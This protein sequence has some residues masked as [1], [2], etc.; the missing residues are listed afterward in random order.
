MHR[1]PS[2]R[3][4]TT[5]PS[6]ALGSARGPTQPPH[7]L[8]SAEQYAY[9]QAKQRA[10]IKWLLS[11]AYSHK[12]P[13]ELSEP[14]Y[15]DHD[16]KSHEDVDHLKPHI[17]HALANAELYCMALSILYSDPNYH[18]LNHW[19]IIQALARKGIYVA[20]PADCALT[21]TVLIQT[22]PL[23]MS[24]HM[25]VTEAVMG[26]VLKET[27]NVDKVKGVIQRL[28]K[29]FGLEEQELTSERA[30]PTDQE[31]AL[32][33]WVNACC[34]VAR[35]QSEEQLGGEDHSTPPK[36]PKVQD[37]SDLSDGVGLAVV[38]SLYCPDE[39]A[40]TE[41]AL[42]DPPSM[43]DSLYNIQLVQ[44][45]CQSTPSFNHCHLSIEDFVYLHASIK[46]NV[47]CFMAD[48]FN[49]L[50]VKPIRPA[51]VPGVPKNQVI[52][53]PDPDI[54][55]AKSPHVIRRQASSQPEKNEPSSDSTFVVQRGRTVPTLSSVA[56]SGSP[57]LEKEHLNTDTKSEERGEAEASGE[58][59]PRGGHRNGSVF[60][61]MRSIPVAGRP[62]TQESPTRGYKGIAGRRSRRNS[63]D[64]NTSQLSLE[65]LGGSQDN[66]HLLSRNPDKEMKTHSGRIGP[67]NNRYV[68][69]REV[70]E[71]EKHARE[72]VGEK[73][74]ALLESKVSFA[75]LRKQKARDQFH[76]SGINI[77]YMHDEKE[78]LPKQRRP[79]SSSTPLQR[80][81]SQKENPNPGMTSWSNPGANQMGQIG[82]QS[83]HDDSSSSPDAMASQLN[84]V[85]M[86]LEQ[87]RKKIEEEKKKMESIM[88]KQREKVGQEAFL[89]AV[90]VKTSS[91]TSK[92]DKSQSS[93][94]APPS[95]GGATNKKA[96]PKSTP[97]RPVTFKDL[98]DDISAVQSRWLSNRGNKFGDPASSVRTP[99]I[100][101]MD[102]DTYTKSLHAMNDSL[103]ELQTDIHRLA[104]QQTQIQH[105]MHQPGGRQ[106]SS[107]SR[108]PMDPQPFYI[109]HE[110]QQ[111]P[112][113]RTWGQPQPI[114]FAHQ[115]SGMGDQ[116]HGGW[117]SPQRQQWGQ[118]PMGN[119]GGF[120]YGP[121]SSQYNDPYGQPYQMQNPMYNGNPPYDQPYGGYGGMPPPTQSFTP[122][123]N[124][125][126]PGP[127]G[128]TSF[129]SPPQSNMV[130]PMGV[131]ASP[132]RVTPFRL[133]DKV[134]SSGAGNPHGS[135]M[136]VNNSAL[137]RNPP[138]G[139]NAA[140]LGSP[141][142]GADPAVALA[143]G[144]GSSQSLSRQTSR[145]SVNGMPG[146]GHHQPMSPPL[147]ESARRL[148]TSVPAPEE[149]DMAPQNISFI[150]DTSHDEGDRRSS[151]PVDA[152]KRLPER[153]SQL[154][155]SSGSKTYRV[156]SSPDKDPSP[157]PTRNRPTISS[158]FKQARRSSGGEN[159]LTS[160]GPSSIRSNTGQSG[161]TE[162]EAETLSQM[163]TERLKDG[164]EAAK[165]F[166]ITFEDDTPKKPKPQLK[167]RRPSSK[168]NSMVFMGNELN[169][170][171]SNSSRKENVP[172][173]VMICIDMNMG[174][175]D[176]GPNSGGSTFRKY[177]PGHRNG[178]SPTRNSMDS[179]HWKSYENDHS[180][181]E[182]LRPAIPRFDIDPDVPLET[183]VA[184]QGT[185]ESESDGQGK[186]KALLIGD[187][188]LKN[189]PVAQDEMQKKKERIMMQSLRR[190]QQAEENR[191]K[192]EEE[193]RARREEESQKEEEKLRKKEEEKARRDAILEQHRLKKEMEKAEEEGRYMPKPVSAR[194]VPK[195]RSAS[196]MG[197][198]PRPK[199][200]HVDQDADLNHALGS[201]RG[202]RGS[203]SNMSGLPR[204]ESR[205]SI[206]DLHD[207][208][209]TPSRHH[210]GLS[211]M[212]TGRSNRPVSRPTSRPPSRPA[213]RGPSRRGSTQYLNEEPS[214]ANLPPSGMTSRTMDWAA[215]QAAA[216]RRRQSQAHD[217]SPRVSRLDRNTRSVSQPRGK[218]D[219]SVSS[220]YGGERDFRGSRESLA[221][222]LTYNP[223]RGSN[224]SIYEETDYYYGG[225]MRDLS[226]RT[227]GR[228][229]SSSASHL[230]LGSYRAATSNSSARSGAAALGSLR[231]LSHFNSLKRG[232]GTGPFAGSTSAAHHPHQSH[233]LA[234]SRSFAN[235][236][237]HELSHLTSSPLA[238]SGR[239]T[240]VTPTSVSPKEGAPTG[241]GPGSLPGYRRRAEFD[242]GASDIS[243]ASGFSAFGFRSGTR[244]YREPTSKSNRTIVLNAIEYVVFPGAVNRDTRE[245]VLD[246]IDRCD[247]PHFLLL[248]RDQKCQFRGLYAYFPD[249]EEVYKIYGTGPKQVTSKMFDHFFKYNSGGKKFTKIHTKSLTV[250]ID[251]FTIHNSLW[252]GKKA[253]LPDKQSMALVV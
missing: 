240:S 141:M 164:A 154:N 253:K 197:R 181:T 15:K 106:D 54:H 205:N 82:G 208:P 136:P 26:L 183:M 155:I 34:E 40:W 107:A 86:K 46:Q 112:P 84:N 61:Q 142:R 187:E 203:T 14:F 247:C 90:G 73:S 230:D 66:I 37:L 220:A 235:L 195:L 180:T 8:Q 242:D 224:A 83:S 140:T 196:T 222:G 6:G 103:H 238:D 57:T 78:D 206:N 65:N 218:R 209:A 194:P 95:Q 23:K 59:T 204:S 159:P 249:T 27:V 25:A 179:S 87:R 245:R 214:N 182:T 35:K 169:S 126:G 223:R 111:G 80:S 158:T 119:P 104:S 128:N 39:L 190:K 12:T 31:E 38:I 175:G 241:P 243:S 105:M 127:Y 248:F 30:V 67:D 63:V 184:L 151:S 79:S 85:R 18:N 20:E 216:A 153:L 149:D 163:K 17:V 45:F 36:F 53:V 166:V 143:H 33:L 165:G 233:A 115:G 71:L 124:G 11:K 116:G 147:G 199:T 110:A 62:S 72:A 212:G 186:T 13:P 232:G 122:G 237:G 70:E 221:S 148:H 77:T 202:S 146:L 114:N 213:S 172:P 52:E 178:G 217:E 192:A 75:D 102:M 144:L 137:S 129:M 173:E 161:L 250:T 69:N 5:S 117:Q 152:L 229:K 49:I 60:D 198:R 99:D 22:N 191:I 10:S 201:N 193:A 29:A 188:L 32:V 234:K 24:A 4:G 189:D 135:P 43:A 174:A 145:D 89:R 3:R 16:A 47:I 88:S 236:C 139:T 64:E 28:E 93:V 9:K 51:K 132:S 239:G 131:G 207:G 97:K 48:L 55:R 81:N 157:S 244:L 160:S 125:Y 121:P 113:R 109:A 1:V 227:T 92:S 134:G 215:R 167:Q 98:T 168:R 21:E 118:R 211:A 68:D 133:H 225:S 200:I 176:D 252:L 91:S 138:Y 42:G 94:G 177:S 171:G 226:G 162:E 231:S 219:S 96:D 56:R 120:G 41:I 50:E 108:H 130:N 185:S 74:A 76:S 150:E 123:P 19:G 58:D 156:H 251:A 44:R 100:E 246:V 101:N 228:R 170:D 210:L 7:H 2:Q